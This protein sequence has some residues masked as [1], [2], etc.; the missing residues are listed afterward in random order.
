MAL[1]GRGKKESAESM[2][3]ENPIA[4]LP[5]REAY[6]RICAGNTRFSRCWRRSG[7]VLQCPGCSQMMENPVAIYQKRQPACPH[8]AEPFESPGFEYGLCDGCGSKFE[9]ADGA[10]PA[11]LPNKT[12]RDEMDKFGISWS[13]P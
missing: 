3:V 13:K 12:Q 2:A 5:G 7:I 9:L 4:P 8:C 6:C 10:R 11:L 1:F